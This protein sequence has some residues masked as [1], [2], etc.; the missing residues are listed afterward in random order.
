MDLVVATT[1]VQT[2]EAEAKDA[3]TKYAKVVEEV[4]QSEK[5]LCCCIFPVK[6]LLKAK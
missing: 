6:V 3:D 4:A 1:C 5:N 2:L